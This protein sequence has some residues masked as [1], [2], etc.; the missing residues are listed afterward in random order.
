M[1][2]SPNKTYPTRLKLNYFKNKRGPTPMSRTPMSRNG[3][4]ENQT[5]SKIRVKED[6]R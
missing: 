6:R 2:P 1:N 4:C 3:I 5:S